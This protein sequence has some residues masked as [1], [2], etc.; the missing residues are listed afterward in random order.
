LRLEKAKLVKENKQGTQEWKNLNK[1]IKLNNAE[2]KQTEVRMGQLREK[3]G[4]TSLTLN[5]LKRRA[6]ELRLSMS[7]M[8][9][10]TAKYKELEK[11]LGQVNN[12][13]GELRTNGK[14]SGNALTRMFRSA[15]KAAT[16]FMG[17]VAPIMGVVFALSQLVN[18]SAELSDAQ[19]DVQKTTNLTK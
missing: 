12:R 14:A 15:G 18:M 4:I 8:T 6:Q 11:E 10:G 2:L 17:V 9:P 3:I 16:T 1:Q 13:L 19:A 7:N 5:Q